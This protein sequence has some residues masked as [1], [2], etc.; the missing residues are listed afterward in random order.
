M[1]QACRPGRR[2]F[3]GKLDP[4]V[5]KEKQLWRKPMSLVS[6]TKDHIEIFSTTPDGGLLGIDHLWVL[7]QQ[8]G[9]LLLSAI[10]S[11]FLYL[12]TFQ[13]LRGFACFPL[14]V[15]EVSLISQ[16]LLSDDH[17]ITFL[18]PAVSSNNKLFLGL[19]N[20][21]FLSL[22]L[23]AAHLIAVRRLLI[24]G[25]PAGIAAGL[26]TVLGHWLLLTWVV[27]G[28]RFVTFPWFSSEPF[29]F[30]AGLYL[31]TSVIYD[32]THQRSLSLIKG[33]E[34]SKLVRVFLLSFAL[35]WTEQACVLQSFNSFS[36]DPRS[37]LLEVYSSNFLLPRLTYSVGLLIGSV[38][39]TTLFGLF[40]LWLFKFLPDRFGWLFSRWVNLLNFGLLSLVFA[41]AVATT[42]YYGCDYL[43]AK[44]LG[45]LSQDRSLLKARTIFSS[46]IDVLTSWMLE[47]PDEQ[48]PPPDLQPFQRSQYLE[49]LDDP[50]TYEQHNF[51]GEY[52]VNTRGVRAGENNTLSNLGKKIGAD[53]GNYLAKAFQF[54]TGE[55]D[56]FERMRGR[57]ISTSLRE[58]RSTF[59]RRRTNRPL[60]AGRPVYYGSIL[61]YDES[62]DYV[63]GNLDWYTRLRKLLGGNKRHSIS[64]ADHSRLSD[65][66]LSL[67]LQ[68][69]VDDVYQPTIE[70]AGQDPSA[71]DE[72]AL[73]GFL[74][75]KYYSNPI[76]RSLL[77]TEIDFFIGRQQSKFRLSPGA[78]ADLFD[79]RLKLAGYYNT[80][81][82]YSELDTLEMCNFETPFKRPTSYATHVYNQQFKGTLRIVRR[83][84]S[85]ELPP[86]QAPYEI[87][88][89]LKFDQP[90]FRDRDLATWHE[91]L[92]LDD[93][94]TNTESAFEGQGFVGDQAKVGAN[95]EREVGKGGRGVG[96]GESDDGVVGS[97][98]DSGGGR[99]EANMRLVNLWTTK[100]QDLFVRYLG[101]TPLY[102]GWDQEDRR[103]VLT[104]S[105]L[106]RAAAGWGARETSHVLNQSQSTWSSGFS[107]EDDTKPKEAE[108]G[109]IGFTTWPLKWEILQQNL[110]DD[111][112]TF[113]HNPYQ[114]HS[115]S[116]K[117][118]DNAEFLEETKFMM[119]R[120]KLKTRREDLEY[121]PLCFMFRSEFDEII[122]PSRGGF[123]WP[124]NKALEP[125]GL[126]WEYVGLK[127]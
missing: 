60:E 118:P 73:I 89:V 92:P 86:P 119:L 105:L 23:S 12:T 74:R 42:P 113:D 82:A 28:L 101:S 35:C 11:L 125:S 65:R 85:L 90:L 27:F 24:Q 75:R 52:A 116:S 88:R 126:V 32:M 10:K 1:D 66:V 26:G 46:D 77:S 102:A 124:G 106:P 45:F 17:R 29:T 4:E 53:I 95:A 104:N 81:R 54:P 68:S 71:G 33:F 15:P 25:I 30:V 14:R 16:H 117:K 37:S 22:P 19:L 99:R 109:A 115:E 78:E 8:G 34:R 41:F 120:R 20:S 91:E 58:P 43:L 7:I 31:T 127:R 48:G 21:F 13:W 97:G 84:F 36:L 67:N 51:G 56:A 94:D 100:T 111:S 55:V 123:V 72:P 93:T 59:E 6:I 44:P 64:K 69:S 49:N 83:L 47:D 38:L 98:G 2:G 63:E 110:S 79:K 96:W 103:F 61:A 50:K 80:L 40:L 87:E 57:V 9:L 112:I 76:Y 107:G 122:P 62:E 108:N 18:Q 121:Y 70:V 5:Y 39:F 3:K 114:L